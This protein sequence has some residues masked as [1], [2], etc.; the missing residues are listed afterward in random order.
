MER[1]Y[2][3]GD[4]IP[5]IS[6]PLTRLSLDVLAETATPPPG[7]VDLLLSA[8]RSARRPAPPAGFTAPFAARVAA[9]DALLASATRADWSQKIVE[10]WTLQELVA[11]LAATDSLVADAIEAPVAGPP[12]TENDVPRRTADMIAYAGGRTPQETRAEW[13]AQAEAIRARAAEM[14][15]GTPIAPG[16]MSFA[17]ADHLLARMLETWIHTTDAAA[18]MRVSLP[19]PVAAHVHPTADFC[20][21]LV[22][23]TMLLSGVDGGARAVRLTLTGP[24]GGAWHVPLDVQVVA[25]PDD[26]ALAETEIVCDV[27]DFCFLLGGRRVPEEFPATIIGDAGLALDVLR[28]APALS[29]P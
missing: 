4:E 21:R 25:R 15:P 19:L 27:V 29:G 23:W 2:G 22:P 13:R 3:H 17:L 20:A 12:L 24:G 26:G 28:C 9:M 14:D 6:D 16:G 8:A 5:G 1:H 18:V 10:G 7:A 11:H